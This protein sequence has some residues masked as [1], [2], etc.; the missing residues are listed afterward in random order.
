VSYRHTLR[1]FNRAFLQPESTRRQ[2]SR[3]TVSRGEEETCVIH[4]SI[5]DWDL[6]VLPETSLIVTSTVHQ[7]ISES[8]R[9]SKFPSGGT[10]T[11]Y[12]C[13]THIRDAA[14]SDSNNL[15]RFATEHSWS[16]LIQRI[17]IFCHTER[18][19]QA[20]FHIRKLKTICVGST[21]LLK[22]I[23]LLRNNVHIRT[24]PL[25]WFW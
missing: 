10:N 8:H 9:N 15:A 12:R 11:T 25:F 24:Q 16:R 1:I 6:W 18:A 13:L 22:L 17:Y 4:D 20:L 23:T 14:R 5:T 19:F 21:F 2:F 3:R 7:H